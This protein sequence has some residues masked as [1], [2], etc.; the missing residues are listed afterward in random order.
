MNMITKNEIFSRYSKEYPQATKQ[1][2]G[3]IIRAVCDVTGIRDKSVIRKFRRIQLKGS[4]LPEQ[5][6][7]KQFY[8]PDSIAALKA[9]WQASSEICGELLHPVISDYVAVLQRDKLW[10]YGDTATA[11]LLQMS[12]ATTKRKVAQFMKI[13]SNRKGLSSTSPSHLKTIIPI[14]TGPWTGKGPGYGQIDTVVHC[15]D[16]L[17]GDMAFTVNYTDVDLLWVT[18]S[19]QWNKGQVATGRSLSSIKNKTPFQI[20]GMHPDTG[21][22]FINWHIKSWA[23]SNNIELTRSRPSHCNDNAYVEQKNGHVVRRFLG[24]ERLDCPDVVRAMNNMYEVL[25][26]YLN[27]F[28]PS[29]KCLEKVRVGSKYKRKYDKA[30]TPYTRLMNSKIIN[31]EIKQKIQAEHDQLNPLLLKNGVAKL[32]REILLIQNRYDNLRNIRH[33]E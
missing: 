23:D 15:G 28:V 19:A 16:S 20:F 25:E 9:V 6:G 31:Q 33:V 12:E 17:L 5:R 7:R 2:K 4:A 26:K 14:F 30:K 8:T 21:S 24:Y 13:K 10:K 11:K 32:L 29:R 18:L 27:H 1:R 3:E 22:E